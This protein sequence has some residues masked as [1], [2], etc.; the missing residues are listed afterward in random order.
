MQIDRGRPEPG[1]MSGLHAPLSY[2]FDISLGP[3]SASD[4]ERRVIY[5]IVVKEKI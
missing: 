2:V 3:E 4:R 5:F 1:Q